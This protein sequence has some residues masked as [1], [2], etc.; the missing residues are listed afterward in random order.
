MVTRVKTPIAVY[1][2][3]G[4]MVGL[5][6]HVPELLSK[7]G[8]DTRTFAAYCMLKGIG[9]DTA[10]RLARGDTNFTTQTLSVVADVLKVDSIA[11]IIDIDPRAK[12]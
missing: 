2:E 8:W 5:R 3:D 11:D 4:V 1:Q 12:E 7:L 6:S 9:Q 10:Y